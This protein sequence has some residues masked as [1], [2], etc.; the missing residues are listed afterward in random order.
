V[1]LAEDHYA[2]LNGPAG[3]AGKSNLDLLLHLELASSMLQ[4]RH[5]QLATVE[6]SQKL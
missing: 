4:L 3:I 5:S 2:L 6:T 1:L